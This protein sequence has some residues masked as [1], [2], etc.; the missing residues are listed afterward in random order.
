MANAPNVKLHRNPISQ[1][2]KKKV[3]NNCGFTATEHLLNC[4]VSNYNCKINFYVHDEYQHHPAKYLNS[5]AYLR[6][7]LLTVIFGNWSSNHI[8]APFCVDEPYIQSCYCYRSYQF[9]CYTYA[10][11][12]AT[13]EVLSMTELATLGRQRRPKYS[14]CSHQCYI[15]C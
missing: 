5:L 14:P 3:L 8:T 7:T 13:V 1:K 6:V 4:L 12:Q 9:I 10:V 15:Q 2:H 11:Y